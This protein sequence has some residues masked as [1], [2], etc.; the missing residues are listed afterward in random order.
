[1]EPSAWNRICLCKEDD[2][3]SLI[4]SHDRR[5][6]RYRGVDNANGKASRRVDVYARK[7]DKAVDAER[8]GACHRDAAN[9]S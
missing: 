2:P 1:M 8:D 3:C 4:S 5:G 7:A 9:S 6:S